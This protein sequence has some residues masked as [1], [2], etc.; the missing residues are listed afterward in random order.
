MIDYVYKN[1]F[2]DS[3]NQGRHLEKAPNTWD[4]DQK[5]RNLRRFRRKET[6]FSSG[7]S[8]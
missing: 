4:F 6:C 5:F 1:N 8:F 2:L 7:N 3:S